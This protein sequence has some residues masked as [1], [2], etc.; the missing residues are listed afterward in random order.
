MSCAEMRPEE[1]RPRSPK[2]GMVRHD[3]LNRSR[4]LSLVRRSL[5]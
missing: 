3:G 2:L 1:R 5:W 4:V